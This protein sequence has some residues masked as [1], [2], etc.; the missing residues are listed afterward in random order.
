[1]QNSIKNLPE[2]CCNSACE[3]MH[4]CNTYCTA[5]Y[6]N[7]DIYKEKMTAPGCFVLF[8]NK[9]ARDSIHLLPYP[10]WGSPI[11]VNWGHSQKNDLGVP[12]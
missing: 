2:G 3:V 1:M 11:D 8:V 9:V 4:L 10:G 7:T 12:L 6:S 5:Y